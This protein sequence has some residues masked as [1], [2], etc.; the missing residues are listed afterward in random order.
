MIIKDLSIHAISRATALK[1]NK[2]N[3]NKISKDVICNQINLKKIKMFFT[4]LRDLFMLL[5]IRFN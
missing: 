5:L 2:I 1:R 4:I 3:E